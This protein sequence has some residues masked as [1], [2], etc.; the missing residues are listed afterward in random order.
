MGEHRLPLGHREQG[1]KFQDQ[2]LWQH[3]AL[4]PHRLKTILRQRQMAARR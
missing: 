2:Q 1:A 3:Q 4:P